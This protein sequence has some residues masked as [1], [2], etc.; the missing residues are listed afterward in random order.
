MLGFDEDLD[1]E[2]WSESVRGVFVDDNAE[3]SKEEAL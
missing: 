2:L 3:L 1:W